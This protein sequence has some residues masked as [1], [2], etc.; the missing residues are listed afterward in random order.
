MKLKAKIFIDE[1]Y[2]AKGS[3]VSLFEVIEN[4]VYV[5]IVDNGEHVRS[6][7]QLVGE[8]VNEFIKT[9]LNCVN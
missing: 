9:T 5:K 3:E 2:F 4:D 6:I 1:R 8:D 7:G